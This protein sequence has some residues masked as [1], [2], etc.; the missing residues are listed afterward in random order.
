MKKY[1]T[2]VIEYAVDQ[3]LPKVPFLNMELLEGVVIAAAMGDKIEEIHVM[4]SKGE[5]QVT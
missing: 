1:I 5:A 2:L 4:I 3:E